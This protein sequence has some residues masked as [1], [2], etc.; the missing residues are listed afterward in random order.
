MNP[1]IMDYRT[2]MCFL[3]TLL[4]NYVKSCKQTDANSDNR[5]RN[6]RPRDIVKDSLLKSKKNQ[7]KMRVLSSRKQ[8]K[9]RSKLAKP[10]I[11]F[12]MDH[13]EV[14]LKH[15]FVAFNED[16]FDPKFILN[17]PQLMLEIFGNGIYS[18]NDFTNVKVL[19]DLCEDL[20]CERLKLDSSG[21]VILTD[22]LEELKKCGL[23]TIVRSV[24]T[25][26][27][28][29]HRR[30]RNPEGEMVYEPYNEYIIHKEIVN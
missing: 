25:F 18:K 19:Q 14:E 24:Y 2:F 8:E 7:K 6:L 29:F 3:V 21:N 9:Q 23:V 17:D 1:T 26:K 5:S 11:V 10:V 30:V 16:A 22:F 27:Q 20:R 4:S 13:P 15:A 28:V 12:V